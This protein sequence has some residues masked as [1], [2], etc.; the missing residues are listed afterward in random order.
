MPLA[1]PTWHSTLRTVQNHI[2][3][4]H[5]HVPCLKEDV[6]GEPD[7]YHIG[8]TRDCWASSRKGNRLINSEENCILRYVWNWMPFPHLTYNSYLIKGS[9]VLYN[10][11]TSNMKLVLGTPFPSKIDEFSEKF[12]TAFDPPPLILSKDF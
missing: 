7:F 6:T 10:I 12:Q 2:K 8:H 5:D 4:R 3:P 1:V 9:S 11:C